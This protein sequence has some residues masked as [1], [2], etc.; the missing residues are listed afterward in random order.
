M[1]SY[2]FELRDG[3]QPIRDETGIILP[4]RD[5]AID[6]A[7]DVARELMKSREAEARQWR[8]DVYEDDGYQ[9]IEI[10]LASVDGTLDNWAPAIRATIEAA[11]DRHRSL[12]ETLHSARRTVRESRA[13][14]AKS[15]GKPYLATER[16]EPTIGRGRAVRRE[17]SDA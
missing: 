10:S 7:Y 11:C 9:V 2:T 3:S 14:V 12:R 13:L 1:P 8:L 16:G 5:R 6:Y 17:K 15:Q 4:D